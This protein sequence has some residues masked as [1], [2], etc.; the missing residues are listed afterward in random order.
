MKLEV[1]KGKEKVN[2]FN[3][4]VEKML[5]SELYNITILK[6]KIKI[7]HQY[8][9]SDTQTIDFI[10]TFEKNDGTIEKYIYRYSNIP[11]IWG[12]LDISKI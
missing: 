2:E 9:Y 1:L 5:L 7:K 6:Q 8:N 3:N 10:H 4:G 12:S 11:T